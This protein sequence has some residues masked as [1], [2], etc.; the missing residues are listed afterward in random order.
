MPKVTV[1]MNSGNTAELLVWGHPVYNPGHHLGLKI[2]DKGDDHYFSFSPISLEGTARMPFKAC[3]QG[4]EAY[5]MTSYAHEQLI[6]G[7][8]KKWLRLQSKLNPEQLVLLPENLSI[9]QVSDKTLLEIALLF[10]PSIQ[11]ELSMVYEPERFVLNNLDIESMISK[12]RHFKSDSGKQL[13]APWAGSLWRNRNT[14]NC[15]S[16]ILEI[17]YAGKLRRRVHSPHDM[18]SILVGLGCFMV[19]LLLKMQPIEM[20]IAMT[21]GFFIGRILGGAYEGYDGINHYLQMRKLLYKDPIR[22]II[23]FK[24]FSS[25]VCAIA[26][27]FIYGP[28]F[29]ALITMPK[30]VAWLVRKLS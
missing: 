18:A 1:S 2:H 11:S 28:I 29:P 20:L 3:H 6:W 27:I 22:V 26:G 25:L 14:H 16:I 21:A 4:R 5:V 13:W 15:A 30:N 9:A 24:L 7:V 23:G 12:I 10:P 17:L 8:R 19:S